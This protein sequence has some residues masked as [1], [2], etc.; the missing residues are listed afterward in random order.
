MCIKIRDYEA[1]I[2]CKQLSLE[3]MLEEHGEWGV[4]CEGNCERKPMRGRSWY[5]Q[6]GYISPCNCAYE[7]E[8]K[9]IKLEI[10]NLEK[11]LYNHLH[12]SLMGKT[13]QL[14]N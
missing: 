6:L 5:K 2:K 13:P 8:Y 9:I 3:I 10:H 4:N 1:Q 7:D 12:T 14:P 11:K